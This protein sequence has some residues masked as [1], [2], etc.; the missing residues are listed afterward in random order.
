MNQWIPT[1]D[2]VAGDIICFTETVFEGSYRRA[3][4]VGQRRITAIVKR[5]SYGAA[6]QQHTF[7][8]EV[9]DC[10]GD[11]ALEVGARI[12]RK[13]RNIYRN[14]VKRCL[15][16]DEECRIITANEKH[17]RGDEAREQQWLRQNNFCQSM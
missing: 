7:T 6:K 8:L 15:W 1:D 5:D 17:S 10:S 13:G 11:A 12:M 4:P 3:K 14:G 2:V 16:W 9:I